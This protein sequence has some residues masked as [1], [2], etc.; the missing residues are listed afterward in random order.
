MWITLSCGAERTQ[1]PTPAGASAPPPAA[2]PKSRD[3]ATPTAASPEPAERATAGGSAP[4]TVTAKLAESSGE[5]TLTFAAD[6]TDVSVKCWGVDGLEVTRPLSPISLARVRTGQ[7]LVLAVDFAAPPGKA[8]NLAVSVS[9]TFGGMRR[10]RVQSF[11]VGVAATDT[12][13]TPTLT[14]RDGRP[15]KLM[16]PKP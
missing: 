14:D 2:D 6:G 3:D 1:T 4:G 5:L 13:A 15:I 8:S 9:G 10:S 7:A 11:T 16:Q 12:L